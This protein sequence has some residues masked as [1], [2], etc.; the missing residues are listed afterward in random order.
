MPPGQAPDIN[1]LY[2]F[3]TADVRQDFFDRVN[4]GPFVARDFDALARDP[5]QGA[6]RHR[7]LEARPPLRQ[8]ALPGPPDR[9]LRPDPARGDGGGDLRHAQPVRPRAVLCAPSRRGCRH[10]DRADGQPPGDQ[11]RRD[12]G[13]RI[14]RPLGR[15]YRVMGRRP[16]PAAATSC[17]TRTWWRTPSA[18]SAGSSPSCARRCRTDGSRRA[19]RRRE[20][21]LAA[22]A[23]AQEGLSRAPAGHAAVLRHRPGRRLAREACARAGRPHPRRVPAGAR[24]PLSR[25]CW[26]RPPRSAAGA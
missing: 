21:R 8:D 15:A 13:S 26:R 9:R 5:A 3:T 24:A 25:R 19:I 20:L 17:A 6:A 1:T 10:D 7:R 16:R 18:P 23:G 11:W 2:R 12:R 14:H 4:G 22:E